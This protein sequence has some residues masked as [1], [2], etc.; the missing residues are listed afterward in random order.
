MRIENKTVLIASILLGLSMFSFTFAQGP[1]ATSPSHQFY[2]DVFI[3]GAPA[4]EG[5]VVK[6]QIN[7]VD[8]ES[9]TVNS[10]GQYVLYIDDPNNVYTGRTIV[11][12]VN[13]VQATTATFCN[14]CLNSCGLNYDNCPE[15]DLSIT[16]SGGGTTGGGAGGGGG[17]GGLPA[18][19]T[20][21]NGSQVCREAWTCSDW[22]PCE[23]GLQRRTCS[24]QNNCGTKN[25]EPFSVQPCS[26]ATGT[27]APGVSGAAEGTTGTTATPP[28]I[29]FGFI[30][31]FVTANP[32]GAYILGVAIL[33]AAYAG[34]R[35]WKKKK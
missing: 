16:T 27:P 1:A 23:D 22:G 33:I 26:T 8:V 3:N 29:D 35:M 25:F 30:T 24:D 9:T 6:A 21:G 19:T 18:I 7:G 28:L 17:G 32:T 13:N 4:P 20:S 31:A 2:G 15:F 12:F 34:W 14:G 11:F 5:T 10:I